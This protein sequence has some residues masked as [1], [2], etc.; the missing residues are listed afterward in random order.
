MPPNAP[1][2]T[3]I[4]RIPF[5]CCTVHR[6]IRPCTPSCAARHSTGGWAGCGTA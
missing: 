5:M 2:L 6:T 4:S 3:V 1:D